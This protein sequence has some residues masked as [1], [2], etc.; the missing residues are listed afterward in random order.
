MDVNIRIYFSL[1]FHVWEIMFYCH[2]FRANCSAETATYDD[3]DM[4][5][6][7]PPRGFLTQSQS[8]DPLVKQNLS[9]FEN[10]TFASSFV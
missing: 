1:H 6:G 3:D 4:Y 5:L 9:H 7:G 8:L 10:K 2:Y